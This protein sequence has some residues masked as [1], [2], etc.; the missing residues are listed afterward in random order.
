MTGD[1]LLRGNPQFPQPSHQVLL[2][3]VSLHQ[4]AAGAQQLHVLDVVLATGALGDDVVNP[5]AESKLVAEPAGP[6]RG[7]SGHR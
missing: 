7:V 3:P 6:R 1:L 5:C 2:R 4:L